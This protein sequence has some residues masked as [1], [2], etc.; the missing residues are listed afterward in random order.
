VRTGRLAGLTSDVR[1]ARTDP[2]ELCDAAL[3]AA[4]AAGGVFWELD[5]DRARA[6]AE[7]VLGLLRTDAH[8]AILGGVPVAV[9]DSFAVSGLP[10]HLGL[11]RLLVSDRDAV[12]VTKLR[13]AGAIVIGTTAMDQLAWTMTGQ[14]PGYPRY[15]NPVVRG[16]S[17][18]GSSGGAAAA[19]AA[20]T[21]PLALA[22][23]SA[24]SLRVPAAWCGVVGFKPSFGA[25]DLDGCAPLAPCL[26]TAGIIARGVD[27]CR[28]GF[29][30]LSSAPPEPK[31]LAAPR[32]GV[33]T[34]LI[35]AA[36]CD[37][38]VLAG[39]TGTLGRLRSARVALREV[40]APPRIRGIG[41]VFAANLASRWGDVL[42]A[43]PQDLVDPDVRIGVE[44][45]RGLTAS[46]YVRACDAL[47]AARRNA[48]R[49]FAE[50]DVLA[51][52]TAPILPPTVDKP[53]PVSVASALTLPWSALGCPAISIP[54][55]TRMLTGCGFQ[56]IARP[57]DDMRL[58]SW[59]ND[60]EEV[61]GD[62]PDGATAGA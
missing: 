11:A 55:A 53:A 9:K 30:A 47:A 50:V 54:C 43:E 60:L 36:G 14:A 39:W 12:A 4:A 35:G 26:D 61:I 37:A 48:A 32:V 1:C 25:I 24:G 62:G 49:L 19:V 40:A 52:P 15:D 33:P 28:V 46:D 21:V 56:L 59:A 22:A 20:G 8:T 13:E 18:G 51:L 5:D 7:A 10:Q 29:T 6:D 42:D 44:Y 16:H 31:A 57:G 41:A 58:L 45:G 34:E 2:R 27:D 23:D 3:S 38:E 17:P